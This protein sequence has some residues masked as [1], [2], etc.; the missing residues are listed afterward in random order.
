MI[1]EKVIEQDFV[2]YLV[3]DKPKKINRVKRSFSELFGEDKKITIGGLKL[4]ADGSFGASTAYMFEPFTDSPEGKSGLMILEKDKLYELFNE[5]YKLGF[6]IAC[7]A[8]GDRANRIVVDVFRDVLS[9]N[10]RKEPVRCRIEHASLLNEKIL[11]DAADLGLIFVCQPSFRPP[12]SSRINWQFKLALC[13][14]HPGE[15]RIGFAMF[16]FRGP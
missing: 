2:F 9:E 15:E 3:T 7:H 1:K 10:E 5:T 13:S 11:L 6:H 4:W 12:M 16:L 8:I 14:L